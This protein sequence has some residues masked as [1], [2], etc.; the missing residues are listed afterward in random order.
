MEFFNTRGKASRRFTAFCVSSVGKM[1]RV[2]QSKENA[3][4]PAVIMTCNVPVTAAMLKLLPTQAQHFLAKP[5]DEKEEPAAGAPKALQ[6]LWDWSVSVQLK[7]FGPDNFNKAAR[8]K[9]AAGSE[10]DDRATLNVDRFFFN[11]EGKPMMK[12]KLVCWKSDALWD[13]VGNVLEAPEFTL[14]V[15][16]LQADLPFDG[17][18]DTEDEEPELELKGKD[19]DEAENDKEDEK[20]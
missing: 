14:D 3:R 2:K 7:F 8:P 1:L 16:A 6:Q 19:K 17:E 15:K 13:F 11:D 18:E 20:E 9:A 5:E 4:R 12:I 10:S